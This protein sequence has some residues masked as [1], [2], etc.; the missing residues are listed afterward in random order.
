MQ[1]TRD[2]GQRTAFL[3]PAPGDPAGALRAALSPLAERDAVRALVIVIEGS[4]PSDADD[5]DFAWLE[6]YPLPAIAALSGAV[7]GG[8]LAMALAC[9]IRICDAATTLRFAGVGERRPLALLGEAG[10]VELLRLG[11]RLDAEAARRL[12]VVSEVAPAG[13][14]VAEALRLAGTIASRGPIATRLAREAI[15]RGLEL[16]LAHALR[17]ETDLTLLLQ[18]TKDRAEGVA[19]FLEKRTPRFTGN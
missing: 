3:R 19:A 7:A 1:L 11:L 8:G 12:G 5:R 10:S 18:T 17:F 6:R 4:A 16:P 14:C 15:W 9:D 13:E 2:P